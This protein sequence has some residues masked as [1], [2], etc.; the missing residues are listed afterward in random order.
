M[1]QENLGSD[2]DDFLFEEGLLES[3]TAVAVKRVVAYQIERKMSEAK[4][5]KSEMARRMATSRSSL[6]RL[7]DPDNASVTLKTLQSAVQVLG[8]RLKVECEFPT[9]GA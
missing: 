2:F 7:L 1:T 9:P 5:T 4:L 6:D 8:G 3:T